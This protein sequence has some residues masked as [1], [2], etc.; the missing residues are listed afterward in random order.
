MHY[1]LYPS[2]KNQ[3]CQVWYLIVSIPDRCTLTYIDYQLYST[4]T[5]LLS[6]TRNDKV[7]KYLSHISRIT[8]V[9]TLFFAEY[10][11]HFLFEK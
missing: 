6:S 9:G 7:F 10:T 8:L 4:M 11:T 2:E 5:K 3:A 1:G